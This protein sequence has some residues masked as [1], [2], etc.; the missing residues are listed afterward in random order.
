MVGLLLRQKKRVYKITNKG[1][2]I[3]LL[4]AALEKIDSKKSILFYKNRFMSTLWRIQ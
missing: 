1:A 4:R 3:V 2:D